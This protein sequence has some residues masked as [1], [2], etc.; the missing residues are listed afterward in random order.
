MN[1][2]IGFFN[3]K[4]QIGLSLSYHWA[5]HKQNGLGSSQK[6][7]VS[8]PVRKELYAGIDL[9]KNSEGL[10]G[11]CRPSSCGFFF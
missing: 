4:R 3:V 7:T 1:L 9:A 10:K 5:L 6:Q 2:R 11:L 8:F